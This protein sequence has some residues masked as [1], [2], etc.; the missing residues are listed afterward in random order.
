MNILPMNNRVAIAG[1]SEKGQAEDI[2]LDAK[3]PKA[4]TA[5][6][7]GEKEGGNDTG[8]GDGVKKLK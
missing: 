8:C 4:N 6:E 7:D 2:I 3:L 1:H 5:V